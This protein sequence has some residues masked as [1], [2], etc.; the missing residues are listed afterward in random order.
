MSMAPTPA[1]SSEPTA[2][3]AASRPC[4]TSCAATIS[5]RDPNPMCIVCMGAKHAQAS[6]ADPQGCPHCVLMPEKVLERRLR[7]A[8]TNSQDP[9]LSAATATS[10]IHHPR[11]STSWADMM[12]EESPLM[13]PS[14][15]DLLDQNLGIPWPAAQDAEWAERDLYDGKRLPPALPSS[16]QLLPAVPACMKEISRYWSSPFKSK[17]PTKG[18][19]KLEIQGMGE[20]GLTEPPAVE[21]SVAYHLH[22]IL[23]VIS[24]SSSISLP[25]KMDRLTIYQRMYKYAAQSVCSL[26]A[27]FNLCLPRKPNSQ[28]QQV[29]R[30][31]FAATAAAVRGGRSGVR[32][33]RG[34][35]G[36]QSAH[37]AKVENRRPWGKHSFAAAA[38]KNKP[39][40]PGEGKRS[41]QPSTP[42]T[43]GVTPPF[44]PKEKEGVRRGNQITPRFRVSGSFQFTRSTLSVS[45]SSS[46][47]TDLWT[48]GA[49]SPSTPKHSVCVTKH[50]PESPDTSLCFGG[51][52]RNKMCI[53]AARQFAKGRMSPQFQNKNKRKSLPFAFVPSKGS[54]RSSRGGEPQLLPGDRGGAHEQFI[55]GS[56]QPFP[57]VTDY[58]LR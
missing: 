18:C 7:V 12:E 20:L 21:P 33:Q 16:K 31:G 34:A 19:S 5:G 44:S 55:P 52:K 29:P 49:V 14:S 54:S 47:R 13:P 58:N 42:A 39:S 50:C 57:M 38:A 41:G 8:V 56:C 17:L 2:K 10:D 3:E 9:C 35:G 37:Q 6:L 30:A 22:P 45:S 28:P 32:M 27:A 24:A 4:P 46:G 48:N 40:H 51:N 11:A 23:R 53:S 15:E 26:N 43:F 25:N 36:P 1:K